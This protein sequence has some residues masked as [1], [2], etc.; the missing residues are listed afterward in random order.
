MSMRLKSC[1]LVDRDLTVGNC[2]NTDFEVWKSESV[3][4]DREILDLTL[5]NSQGEEEEETDKESNDVP[6]KKP[7]LSEIAHVVGLQKN[8][9]GKKR[10]SLSLIIEE[11][12][13]IFFTNKKGAKNTHFFPSKHFHFVNLQGKD[14]HS[15]LF[16]TST[17]F[18]YPFSVK[19]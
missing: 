5:I 11:V 19:N 14:L 3:I 10:Q 2:I 12:L 9:G 6:P 18:L 1:G 13:Q 8:S 17:S 16:Q 15:I 7:K 4:T